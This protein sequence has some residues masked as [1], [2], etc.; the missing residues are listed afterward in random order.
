M[1][2]LFIIY[3][4]GVVIVLVAYGLLLYESGEVTLQDVITSII[5]SSLSWS[6]LVGIGII[7]LCGKFDKVIWR[8]KTNS[9]GRRTEKE[10]CNAAVGI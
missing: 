4:V 5:V 3:L 1:G 8:K 10:D 9:Y 7:W 6:I 2:T